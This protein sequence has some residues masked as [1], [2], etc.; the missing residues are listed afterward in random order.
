[1]SLLKDK[2]ADFLSKSVLPKK[3]PN[4][5]P[6]LEVTSFDL[7]WMYG[8]PIKSI[9]SSGNPKPSSS[10]S[11][12][13]NVITGPPTLDPSPQL[14][15]TDR[16]EEGGFDTIQIDTY[17]T[18]QA[19]SEKV[20]V[21]LEVYDSSNNLVDSTTSRVNAGGGQPITFSS[22]FTPKLTDTYTVVTRL[23]ELTGVVIDT[24]VLP[25]I[26]LESLFLFFE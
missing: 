10:I 1:M 15:Y 20:D 18:S 9:M 13:A 3:V 7:D 21:L 19:Y 24:Q 5:V 25:N 6:A 26:F 2:F 22:W 16:D 8:S 4:P 17:V 23:V 11:I 14:N 12:D